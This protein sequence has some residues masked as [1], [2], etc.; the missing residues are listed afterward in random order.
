MG[1]PANPRHGPDDHSSF[2]AL[3]LSRAPGWILEDR[4]TTARCPC[5]RDL[6]LTASGSLADLLFCPECRDRGRPVD[7]GD[8]YDD[9]GGSG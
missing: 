2:L 3:A 6:F 8:P 5:C 7:A 4:S 9:V 1:I